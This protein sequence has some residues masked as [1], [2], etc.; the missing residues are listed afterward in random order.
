MHPEDM[1]P[2]FPTPNSAWVSFEIF[3]ELFAGNDKGFGV[4]AVAQD[5]HGCGGVV[6]VWFELSISRMTPPQPSPY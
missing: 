1:L 2:L 6:A 3:G 5:V 4:D